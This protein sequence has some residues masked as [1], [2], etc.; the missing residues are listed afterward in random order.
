MNFANIPGWQWEPSLYNPVNTTEQLQPS[1]SGNKGA[2]LAAWNDNGADATTQLEAYY[3]MREG[4]PVMAARAWA[5]TRGTKIAS[6][7]LSESVAF[8]AAKAPGQNLDRR[9]HSAQVDMKSPNLLSW[10]TSLN[11]STASLDFGS[12]GPPYTL[13]L[14]ISSPF[15]LSGPDTSLS[16]SKSS[17]ESSG[18]IETIM[19]TTADGFEYPLRSVSPSDGF[20]LGHP[21]R[22]WT[23]Q[24]SSSHEPVPITL[25]AT[26]RIETDVVNGSR[27]WAN[28]TFVGRF[29]V[30][31]FG[32]RNTLFSW[33][34]MALVA[35]LDSIEGG[36]TSLLLQAGTRLGAL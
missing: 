3:A 25:P 20:D 7:D 13:T 30:F 28:D 18:S 33:S 32:G 9:F 1:A 19:F 36:V 10:K 31:V 8:L 12:Y 34:Q 5:G 2:I 15:T 35:P 4:I 23:N 29:E 14:E 17:N 21:G 24:S 26:L 6:D 27:V 11:N 16:L 22:I